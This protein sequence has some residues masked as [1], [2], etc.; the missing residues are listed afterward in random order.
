[1]K[2]SLIENNLVYIKRRF[3]VFN[4]KLEDPV[5]KYIDHYHFTIWPDLSVR[6]FSLL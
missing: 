5:S 1:M 3:E 2:V 4:M 6:Y